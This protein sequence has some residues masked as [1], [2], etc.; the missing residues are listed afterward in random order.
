MLDVKDVQ[1]FWRHEIGDASRR[2]GQAPSKWQGP[3]RV[4][5]LLVAEITRRNLDTDWWHLSEQ[6]DCNDGNCWRGWATDAGHGPEVVFRNLL[7][8]GFKSPRHL[9]DAIGEFA[10]IRQCQWARDMLKPHVAER[11]GIV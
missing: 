3:S 5:E 10:K 9:I 11:M 8:T 2:L 6:Y 4:T 7:V 1:I